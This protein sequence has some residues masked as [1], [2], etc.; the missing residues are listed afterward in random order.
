MLDDLRNQTSP[1]NMVNKGRIDA[2]VRSMRNACSRFWLDTICVPLQQ[3]NGSARDQ[4]M[5]T[6][7][8]VYSNAYQVLVLDADLE[9]EVIPDKCEAFIRTSLCGWMGRLWVLHEATLANRLYVKF[10]NGLLDL[11]KSYEELSS[12]LR[13]RDGLTKL[14]GVYGTLNANLLQFF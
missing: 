5:T 14:Q 8:D 6:M 10:G 1:L 2:L 13:A 7:K 11:N 3:F 12:H 4:A 9:K